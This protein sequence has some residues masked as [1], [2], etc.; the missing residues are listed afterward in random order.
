MKNLFTAMVACIVLAGCQKNGN[1]PANVAKVDIAI[2][3]P[4]DGATY[5]SGDTIHIKADVT[6]SSQLHGCEV[7]I[8]DT[9]SGFVL[10][11]DAQHVHADKFVIDNEWVGATTVPM[12][13]TLTVI[14]Y[15]DHNG[16]EV[17]KN[18]NLHL[19]P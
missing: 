9:V 11:D 13:V 4:A 19:E 8:T 3:A 15:I 5:H 1:E 6:Y 12:D 7:L 18:L 14:A 17:K 2:A 16:N 10:Y